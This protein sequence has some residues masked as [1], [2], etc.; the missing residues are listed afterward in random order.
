MFFDIDGTLLSEITGQVPES[1]RQALAQARARGHLVFVNTGRTYGELGKIRNLVEPDGWLCGC[2]TYIQAEG[3][4]L[5]HQ[6]MDRDSVLGISRKARACDVDCFLEGMEGCFVLTEETR[7]PMGR[8]LRSKPDFPVRYWREDTGAGEI[9]KFCV[10]ADEE[11]WREEFFASLGPEIQVIDRGGDFYE[12]VPAGYSKAS[13][14]DRI[15][16]AYG[17]GLEDAYV[18]GDS[19]NDISMFEHVPNAVLMGK[20]DKQLEPYAS[21]VTRTVE[22]DGIRYA[23]ESLGL[24]PGGEDRQEE[25]P[26]PAGAG[27]ESVPVEPAP[28]YF[29]LFFNLKDRKI[30]VAG[31]GTVGSRRAALLAE[32]GA[33]VKVVAPEG[34]DR[35]EELAAAGQ[36][37]WER[38]SFVPD[39]LE[40][41][42]LAVAATD[43]A[44]VNDRIAGLCREQKIPVNHAGDQSRCDVYFPGIARKD[45][46][47]AGITASGTDHGLAK[48]VTEKVREVLAGI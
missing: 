4:V 22:E 7:Y 29:P 14:I 46:V 8:R 16:E 20:H 10:I 34:N 42:F 11:S 5:V 39:D 47:V 6:V 33:R 28:A 26:G 13:A 23:M 36:V 40:G 45:G 44:A 3:R 15:L 2:G 1:A 30:L 27:A 35:M 32:F 19:T 48:Q 25:E 9:E 17:L 43:D 24:I 38:R 37:S 12:C 21:F 41:C 18:F 31:A